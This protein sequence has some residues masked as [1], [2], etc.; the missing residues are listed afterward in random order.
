MLALPIVCLLSFIADVLLDTT[1][2][3]GVKDEDDL[4]DDALAARGLKLLA[5]LMVC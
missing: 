3:L 5:L 1:D 2:V 4:V